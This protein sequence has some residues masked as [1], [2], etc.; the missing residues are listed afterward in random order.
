MRTIKNGHAILTY[1]QVHLDEQKRRERC[2]KNIR[3]SVEVVAREKN[4]RI[5]V[6]MQHKLLIRSMDVN[7]TFMVAN[8]GHNGHLDVLFDKLRND[9]HMTN[10]LFAR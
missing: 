9:A 7:R 4:L 10:D 2:I 3:M 5:R 6:V 1:W 8:D